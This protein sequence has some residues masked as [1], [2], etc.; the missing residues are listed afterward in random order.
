MTINRGQQKKPAAKVQAEQVAAANALDRQQEALELRKSGASF[1]AI[2]RTLG[3]S[4]TQAYNDVEAALAEAVN[5]N[6]GKAD[7]LRQLELQRLDEVFFGIY[8]RAVGGEL[9]AVDRLLRISERRAKLLG[10]DAPQA[11][12]LGDGVPLN[13]HI[14]PKLTDVLQALAPVDEDDDVDE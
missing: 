9:K 6:V 12:D 7:E 10:L 11:L 5:R 4:T 1:A 8:Q 14:V 13:I 2:A 3:V